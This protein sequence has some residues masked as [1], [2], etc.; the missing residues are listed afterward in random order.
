MLPAAIENIDDPAVV[1]RYLDPWGTEITSMEFTLIKS[2]ELT[3]RNTDL[4]QM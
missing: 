3:V 4:W 2:K 1:V